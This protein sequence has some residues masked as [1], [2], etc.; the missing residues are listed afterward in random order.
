MVLSYC[1]PIV[2]L[3]SYVTNSY[4]LVILSIHSMFSH[5]LDIH[6]MNGIN[7]KSSAFLIATKILYIGFC[8][9]DHDG[10][11]GMNGSN[12]SNGHL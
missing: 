4:Q 8:W 9:D 7:G 3:L 5:E 11:N 12:G 10:M 2:N 1:N 6:G